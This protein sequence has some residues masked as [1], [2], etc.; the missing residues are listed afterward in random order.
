MQDLHKLATADGVKL[1]EYLG[2]TGS[3]AELEKAV[4]EYGNHALALHLLGHVLKTFQQGDVKKRDTI[5]DLLTAGDN[6][7]EHRHAFKVMHSY[8]KYLNGTTELQV[9]MIL[10]LFD[11]AIELNLMALLW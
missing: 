7:E 6:N 2:V 9:L 1:L 4:T 3:Q 8:L 10:G 11:Y 5:A